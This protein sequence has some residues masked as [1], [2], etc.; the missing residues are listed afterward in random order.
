MSSSIPRDILNFCQHPS[1]CSMI[2]VPVPETEEEMHT[3][4]LTFV[5]SILWMVFHA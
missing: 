1:N 3:A 4:A 2:H 5:F